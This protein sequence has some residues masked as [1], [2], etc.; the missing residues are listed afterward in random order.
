[1]HEQQ[2]KFFGV[3]LQD[4]RPPFEKHLHLWLVE[5]PILRV[6]LH[7][8]DI[9]SPVPGSVLQQPEQVPVPPAQLSAIGQVD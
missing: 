7:R 5:R 1:M 3:T 9:G 6:V 4:F 8:P 2:H